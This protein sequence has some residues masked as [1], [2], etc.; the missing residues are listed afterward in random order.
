[1]EHHDYSYDQV[2]NMCLASRTTGVEPMIRVRMDGL[3]G[4]FFGPPLNH[5]QSPSGPSHVIDLELGRVASPA[6]ASFGIED[7]QDNLLAG[8]LNNE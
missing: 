1:M 4:L 5:R 6:F 8:L 2:F 7:R 3:D